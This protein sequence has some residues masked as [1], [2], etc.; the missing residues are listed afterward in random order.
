MR[1]VLAFLLL[2]ATARV[3]AQ[4]ARTE[5]AGL[6]FGVPVTWVR[7]PAPSDMRA[8]QF[9]VPRAPGDAED[10]ELVLFF[11]GKGKGGSVDDNLTRWYGQFEQPDGRP[12]RDAAVITIRTVK[13]LK[14]TAVDLGGSYKGSGMKPGDSPA[15]RPN[16]HMLAAVIEGES[17]PWFFRLTGPE[18]TAAQAKKDFDAMLTSLEAHR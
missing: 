13:D 14:V 12:S 5:A 18:A 10:G 7:T 9:R 1:L 4:T 11:F 17:G 3:E 15:A 6:R 2:A 8:A 16:F